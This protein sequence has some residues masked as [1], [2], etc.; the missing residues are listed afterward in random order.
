M[1]DQMREVIEAT[2]LAEVKALY[3]GASKVTLDA[4]TQ[5]AYVFIGGGNRATT[6]TGAEFDGL[7]K[8]IPA[9]EE[10]P[11]GKDAP[12]EVEPV[13]AVITVVA[14]KG[15]AEKPAQSKRRKEN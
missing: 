12:A 3:P 7:V 13:E 10:P 15:A 6:V 14:E 5:T 9:G 4:P 8:V 2:E 11:Q 1:A